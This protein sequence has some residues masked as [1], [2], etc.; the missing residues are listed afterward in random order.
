MFTNV[1]WDAQLHFKDNIFKDMLTWIHETI[2][3]INTKEDLYSIIRE[4]PG[5]FKG[6]QPSRYTVSIGRVKQLSCLKTLYS[7]INGYG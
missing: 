2:K 3:Y 1:F 4:H 7:L 5:E 6:Q